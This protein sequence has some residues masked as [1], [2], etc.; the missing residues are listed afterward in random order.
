MRYF[1]GM[2]AAFFSASFAFG[3]DQNGTKMPTWQDEIANGLLSY[4]Q[5]TVDDFPIDDHAHPNAGFWVKAF[6]D[7][8]YH[9]YLKPAY[10][11]VVYAY[12]DQWVVFSGFSRKES[13]RESAMHD[14]K[15]ALPYAQ[16]LLD[17]NEIY[18]RQLA[19]V[20][21]GDLPSGLGSSRAA[22]QTDLPIR[23]RVFCGKIY[24]Q[25]QT[26][27]AALA[28]ATA[29]GQNK[30]KLGELAVTIKKRLDAL[31]SPAPSPVPTSSIPLAPIRSPPPPGGPAVPR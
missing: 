15:G 11:G 21:P 8:H 6:I 31:P 16:A 30:K 25:V 27:R 13:S 20:Q 2:I 23:V 29:N 22:A 18:A 1:Q 26:E 28:T 4:H 10:G 12:I 19:A 5:L 17:I 24:E 3:Q 14:M 7:P 9:C